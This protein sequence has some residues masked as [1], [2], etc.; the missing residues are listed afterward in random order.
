MTRP[1][2]KP[3]TRTTPQPL[4]LVYARASADPSDQRI[5]VDRQVKLCTAKAEQLWPDSE[6][7]VYRDDGISAADPTTH[8]PGYAAFLAAVRSAR[9]GELAGVVVNEQ[10]RLTRQGDGAWDQLVVTLTKAGVTEVETLRS[11][12]VSVAPGNRLVGRMLAVI[13]SEEVERVKARTQDAH[14]ELFNEGRPSGRAPY[15]YRSAKDAQGRPTFE[16]DPDQAKVVRLVFDLAAQGHAVSAIV[17]RL[18]DDGVPPPSAAW[19]FKDGRTLTTWKQITV[20]GLLGSASV[21]GLRGHSDEN[22]IRSTVPARWDAIVPIAQWR[23]VQRMLGQPTVVTSANGETYRVRTRAKAKARKYLLSRNVLHCGKCDSVLVAQPQRRHGG[24]LVPAY[25]CHPK[26]GDPKAC[27]G[28]SISPADELETMVVEAVQRRLVASSKL[29]RRLEAGQNQQAARWREERD[30]AKGRL[31]QASEM[32][33]TGAID[34]DEFSAMRAPMMAAFEH[35]EQKLAG[36]TTDT[37]LPSA[38]DVADRWDTLTLHQQRAVV[39][40]L[41]GRIVIAP[42]RGGRRLGLDVARVGKPQWLA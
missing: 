6:V 9:K 1:K 31:L 29:R 38:D 42:A 7:R 22:G 19:K 4:A 32:F 15:G 36:V 37:T 18:N 24:Q 11:G 27:G 26:S 12:P 21:A 3:K 10:S 20:R 23:Q 5:S 16:P 8:R 13:D 33:G 35:A 30:A 28:V 17:E 2:P 34:R 40:R 39:E 14:R 41:I 25:A